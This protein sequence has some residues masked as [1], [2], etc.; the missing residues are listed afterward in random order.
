M[1]AYVSIVVDVEN[2][3]SSILASFMVVIGTKGN[4]KIRSI[5]VSIRLNVHFKDV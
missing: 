2:Y 5:Y 1:V 4:I 3:Y